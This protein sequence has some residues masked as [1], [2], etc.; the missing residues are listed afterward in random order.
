MLRFAA[1]RIAQPITRR[2]HVVG[3]E[4]LG[5]LAWWSPFIRI[6]ADAALTSDLP[7]KEHGPDRPYSMQL[8]GALDDRLDLRSGDPKPEQPKEGLHDDDGGRDSNN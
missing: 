7:V 3:W 2:Q 6:I 1:G 4:V 8:R 5:V